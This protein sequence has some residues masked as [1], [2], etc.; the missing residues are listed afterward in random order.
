MYPSKFGVIPSENGLE[1]MKTILTGPKY[2]Y[3]IVLYDDVLG[4][5]NEY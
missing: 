5:Q 1:S 4:I 2:W 3:C